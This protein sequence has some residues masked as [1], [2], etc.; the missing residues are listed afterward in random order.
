ML[1]ALQRGMWSWELKELLQT[2]LHPRWNTVWIEANRWG[3]RNRAAAGLRT[4]MGT[5]FFAKSRGKWE[6]AVATPFSV[7]LGQLPQNNVVTW[8]PDE[9]DVLDTY[10]GWKPL[11]VQGLN[12]GYLRPHPALDRWLLCRSSE[13]V[14]STVWNV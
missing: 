7:R 4:D 8:K 10:I 12:G 5:V 13:L 3:E 6:D 11:I 2:C 9:S 1:P 14:K